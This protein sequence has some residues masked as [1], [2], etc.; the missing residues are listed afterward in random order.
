MVKIESNPAVTLD[1]G[2]CIGLGPGL[3]GLGAT[4]S[5]L[6]GSSGSVKKVGNFSYRLEGVM[7][8]FSREHLEQCIAAALRADSA[9]GCAAHLKEFI[10]QAD[11]EFVV[12]AEQPDSG[13]ALI[14]ND[15]LGRLPLFM[16]KGPGESGLIIGRSLSAVMAMRGT[17]PGP[18]RL[19]IA[20]RLLFSYPL[21]SRTEHEGIAS[22]PESGLVW[23]GGCGQE[24]TLVVGTVDYGGG[25]GD[26]SRRSI[27]DRDEVAALGEELVR[28][29]ERRIARFRGWIPTLALSGG[30]DSR[31]VACALQR[32]GA[33]VETISR[34]DHLAAPTDATTAEHVAAVLGL[35]HH[36]M[37]CGA[38]G[39]DV[40]RGLAGIGEGGLAI[41]AGH[42]L[43]FLEQIRAHLGSERFLLTG[44][45]GDKTIA[46]LLPLGRMTQ[47]GEVSRMMSALSATEIEGVRLVTGL[48]GE[49]IRDYVDHSLRGQPGQTIQ[50][51]M[52]ALA[53]RQRGRR[54]LNLGEDR[55]RSVYWSTSPFYAPSYFSRANALSDVCKQRDRLYL[56]L[57][58]WF[59]DQLARI[60]RPG[61]G[62]HR[63]ADR[64]L[65]EG[66]LQMSRSPW[67]TSLYRRMKP[68]P[69]VSAFSLAI[70]D[71]LGV[72]QSR[73][74][75]IWEL[76]DEHLVERLLKT[77]PSETFRSQFLALALWRGTVRP[78]SLA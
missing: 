50:E 49:N 10:A 64:V 31:L 36:A 8:S 59:D 56:Q 70:Q 24:P 74:G 18:D 41:S 26:A 52:R 30:F 27:A 3:P 62:R 22:F 44:D 7:Y 32:T 63:L 19:G 75:G 39:L 78:N 34:T 17:T 20:A 68:K 9:A 29:C 5:S 51:K 1:R 55:N 2:F 58:S 28:A 53:F 11:G 73:G 66:H 35:R 77:P 72:A 12:V 40:T 4:A 13:R 48:T 71:D 60:P 45:G 6:P 21:D 16:A 65:L 37:A 15:V 69:V 42:M 47:A 43:G 38:I 61:R 23:V 54:W 46:P 33:E 14:F 76:A 25:P 67:L 57:L